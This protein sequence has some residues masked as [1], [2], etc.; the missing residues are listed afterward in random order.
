MI[1]KGNT[2]SQ[3][4]IGR[5]T[6][7]K[8]RRNSNRRRIVLERL[9][10]RL[11][12][13][14]L[15]NGDFSISNPSDPNYG[16][17]TKGNATIANGEG[18]LNEGT[19]V[20]TEFSQSFTIAPGTTTLQFS[21]LASDLVANG[22]LSPPDAFEA[23]LLNTQT[24]QPLVGPATGLS[25]TDAFLNIQQ[26][27]E[28]YYAPG[29]TVPGAGASGSVASL[30]YPE[31]INVDLS[32]VPANT[33]ATLFFD[34]I[35]F[36]PA[37]SVVRVTSVSVNQGPA[38]PPVSFILDP[39]TDSGIVGDDLTNIDPVNLIGATDPNQ[40]VSL[41]IGSDGFTDG[42]T[43]AD[44]NGHFTFTDVTLA[45]GANPVQ[46][47]ATNSAGTNIA[48]RTI[49]VDNQPPTGTLENPAPNSTTGQDLGYVDV[50][51]TAPGPAA[52]DPTTFGAQ[53][54]TITGATVDAVQD[55]GNDLER[56]EYTPTGST[57][58]TGTINVTEVA[59]Q[60]ADLAGNVD[61]E[62][63]QS[64]TYQPEIVLAPAANA[65]SVT[66]AENIA[67]PITLAGTDPNA[68]PLALG[69]VVSTNPAH[70]TLSGNAPNLIYTPTVGYF[71]PDSFQFT[72]SNGVQISSP[73]TVSITVVGTPAA[74]APAITTCQDTSTEIT[75][76]CSDTNTPALPLTFSV[77]ASPAHGTL[78]GTA[79]NLTYTPDAGYFGSDDFQFRDG[80]GVATSG[81]ATVS[82]TIVGRPTANSQS[83]TTEENVG[84]AITL[85]GSDPNS[86]PRAIQFTV[87]VSPAHGTLSG[88]VPNV[89]YTPDAGYSGA[90]SFQ[91]TTMNDVV[92]SNAA[93]VSITV[94]PTT[95]I[96]LQPPVSNG[97]AYTTRENT[98]LT[99]A[100]PGVLATDTPAGTGLTAVLTTGPAHGTLMLNADGSFVYTPAANYSGTD[101]FSYQAAEGTTLGNVAVVQLA[102][103]PTITPS[104]LRLIPDTRYYNYVRKRRSIDPA[105][106]DTW[107]PQIGALIGME[108]AGIPTRPT[109]LV[110]PNHHFNAAADRK[111]FDENAASF[112]AKQPILGALF[113]LESPWN[114]QT[115]LLPDTAYYSEQ[116]AAL[117]SQSFRLPADKRLSGRDLC[118][119]RLRARNQHSA[120]DLSGKR[121]RDFCADGNCKAGGD[122]L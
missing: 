48:S 107:H 99:V 38:P 9:E 44:A 53:N 1:A 88:T 82:I 66:L 46:I 89:V 58:P 74:N 4:S 73:A 17:T 42:T 41:A 85:G 60:V 87:T 29:V 56:Y 57:L 112:D 114:G 93:T 30:S 37:T 10:D 103:T 116:K 13:S 63:S 102:I 65:Q 90:D 54:I 31:Q 72:A 28:V 36:S 68:P 52:I 91:F 115:D 67:Q 47:E 6:Q 118:D 76:S 122:A 105:R 62:A 43:T 24:D 18:I 113:Q 106:F 69:F 95:V 12:P 55:L 98:T 59:G 15:L 25:N 11:V 16:W 80:N 108:I 96:V 70:G 49:T 94:V 97:H 77:T 101:S 81:P 86:P 34:L 39:A 2:R 119:R 21:I 100:A 110:S 51:W 61:A 117:R 32:S 5:T 35:G 92:T 26:T 104:S 75:L 79:P 27:G 78:S 83:V 45:E 23:A 14:G 22:A 121:K 84:Q 111:L 20:Q 3:K 8:R 64:F 33:Q 109:I 71:G 40:S 19:T 50:Q 7:F 120:G